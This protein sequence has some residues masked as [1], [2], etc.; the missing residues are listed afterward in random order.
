MSHPRTIAVTTPAAKASPQPEGSTTGHVVGAAS[1]ALT[2]ARGE[3]APSAACDDCGL[4][5]CFRQRRRLFD[6]VV[7]SRE[8]SGLVVVRQ[9]IVDHRQEPRQILVLLERLGRGHSDDADDA[10]AAAEAEEIDEFAG[11]D[12]GQEEQSAE[13]E[14][15]EPRQPFAANVGDGQ[16]GV[17]AE[18]VNE[19]A[20]LPLHQKDHRLARR[21]IGF[22]DA[23]AIDAVGAQGGER[24]L[25]RRIPPDAADHLRRDVLPH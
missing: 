17:R 20:V 7:L 14:D 16:I 15:A 22:D 9:E 1:P 24:N 2:A 13:I 4:R 10:R 19:A 21:E 6:G 12:P 25:R 23:L 5:A 18:G 8:Q 3:R 11:L